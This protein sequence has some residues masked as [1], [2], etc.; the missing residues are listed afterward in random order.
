[1][2]FD[3]SNQVNAFLFGMLVATGD[4]IHRYREDWPCKSTL[5]NVAIMTITYSNLHFSDRILVLHLLYNIRHSYRPEA[6]PIRDL[7]P[8]AGSLDILERFSFSEQRADTRDFRVH[9]SRWSKGKLNCLNLPFCFLNYIIFLGETIPWL[10]L[11]IGDNYIVCCFV[12]ILLRHSGNNR[13]TKDI[14]FG[15]FD[16]LYHW[17]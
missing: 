14:S 1:M 9:F 13:D 15:H 5:E 8:A 11:G 7:H 2:F 16:C 6:F 3:L 17:R 10:D 4:W 12:C